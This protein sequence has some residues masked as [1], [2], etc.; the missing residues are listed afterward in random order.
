MNDE[1]REIK[2]DGYLRQLI[3]EKGLS[4]DYVESHLSLF[5][6]VRES[7]TLCENCP[8]LSFCPQS[9]KGERL[10]LSYDGALLRE[11]EH[12]PKYLESKKRSDFLSSYVYSDISENL[13]DLSL[14]DVEIDEKGIQGLLIECY[15]ILDEKRDK[16]L[17]IAG[18]LGVGKT[19]VCTALANDLVRKGKKVAFVKVSDF[20]NDMRRSVTT[21]TKR[22]DTLIRK[23]QEAEVLFLDDIGSESVSS[24]SRDDVLFTIL[25]DRMENKRMTLFTSNLNRD[26]LSKHFTYDKNDRSSA[27]NAKRLSERIRI[28]SDEYVLTGRNKRN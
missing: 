26:D 23:L 5:R 21:D 1:L 14:S 6:R 11:A 2:K 24:F 20:I 7:R 4:D 22:Y 19:Y 17:Y 9:K 12:C 28:L 8:G 3:E 10:S 18:D 25:D 16:G 27:M 15:D 13:A